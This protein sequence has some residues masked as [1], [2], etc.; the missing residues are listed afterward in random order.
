[1]HG[2]IIACPDG[3]FERIKF[4]PAGVKLARYIELEHVPFDPPADGVN[5]CIHMGMGHVLATEIAFRAKALG[6]QL[7][8]DQVLSD[9]TVALLQDK[10]REGFKVVLA[11]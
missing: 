7:T 11:A 4:S 5:P 6:V 3:D 2:F 1:M 8:P 9:G 10:H